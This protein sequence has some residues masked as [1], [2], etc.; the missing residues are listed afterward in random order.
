MENTEQGSRFPKKGERQDQKERQ[1]TREGREMVGKET[2]KRNIE[3]IENDA[4]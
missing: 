2:K 1:D 3:E 4:T